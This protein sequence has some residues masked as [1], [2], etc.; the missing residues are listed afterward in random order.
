[1]KIVL[2]SPPYLPEYMRNG[3][4]DFVSLSATQWYPIWLGYCGAFLESKGHDV[5][6]IDA[7]AYYLTHE[8]TA[9]CIKEYKPDLLVVYTGLKSED[10]DTAFTDNLISSLGC[11]AVFA[12]PYA[13]IDPEATLTKSSHVHK[14]IQEEFEYPVSEIADGKK[15]STIRNLLY[16][17]RAGA[18][19]IR[20]EPRPYLNTQQLDE[21][22]FVTKF[23][24]KHL[25]L[26][27]YKTIS[28][29]YPF[30][31]IMS[32]RGCKWGLCTYCLWVYTF[33]KGHTYNLRSIENVIEEFN[34]I[35]KEIPEVRSVMIQDD[36]FTD[37][38]ALE[39][40]EAKIKAGNTLPWSCYARGNMSFNTL[41]AM[42]RSSCRNLH[43]G[44]ESANKEILIEIKKGMT[45]EQMEEFTQ[46]AK[47]AKLQIHGDFA[48]GFPGE[49]K[50]TAEETARWAKKLNPHTAQFQLMIPFPG[51][52]FYQQ[53]KNNSWLTPQGEPDYP[54]FSNT[55]IR[56]AAKKAYRKFYLSFQYAFKCLLHPHEYFFG[57]LK[58]IVRAI[59][60]MFWKR[61]DV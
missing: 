57:R 29:Y 13:S 16:R 42:K 35:K 44:Y 40:S 32:G 51:T 8:K 54:H 15:L 55:E 60:A 36:T 5:T 38:R 39:F 33:I 31:D 21:I 59:P 26:R 7:P 49:T 12:G 23:F 52:P 24:K 6:L 20:N 11:D 43:V 14:I 46:H 61:W 50:Q 28:E 10:N 9:H 45:K 18:P 58:S 4:C 17:E 22:P 37:E 27:K 1:M 2:L 41:K 48:F 53:L 47:K 3:R 19:I 56:L 30:V 34:Y 25:N